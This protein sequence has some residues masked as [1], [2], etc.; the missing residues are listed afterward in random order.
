MNIIIIGLGSIA[1]KHISALK[2]INPEINLF[3]LR[4]NR[5]AEQYEDVT[6]LY[7]ANKLSEYIFDFCI[8]SSPTANHANDIEKLI[9]YKIPLFIE[10]PL[11]NSLDNSSLIKKIK[12]ANIKTYVACNLRFLDSLNYVK[13]NFINNSN[14][15][16]NEVNSYCGSYL[17][18][19][20]PNV[21]FRKSYSANKDMGGGVHID[22]IHEIDYLY[23]L[24]GAPTKTNK[25]FK[26]NSSLEINSIDYANFSLEYPNFVSSVKLNYYRRDA[27]RYLEVL[28]NDFSIYVDLLTNSVYRNGELIYESEQKITDTYKPQLEYFIKNISTKSFNDIGEAFDVLKICIQ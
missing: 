13:E 9:S 16:I 25:I 27:K 19:W 17:P 28:F 12:T 2:E 6:N 23:W 26:S 3:A 15:I 22:L 8:I 24:F 11:F 1:K 18:D 4:S 14:L 7:N 20:R 21:D 10:K 5:D